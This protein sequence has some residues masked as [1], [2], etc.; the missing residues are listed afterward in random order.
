ML[1]KQTTKITAVAALITGGVMFSPIASA[2][3]L[4]SVEAE[5]QY[6]QADV[7]GG[8]AFP[9]VTWR[10]Y[11]WDSSGQTRVS[12]TITHFLPIIPNFKFDSQ[13]LEF[14]GVLLTDATQFTAIDLSHETYT[15]FYAPLDNNLTAFHFGVSLKQI[16]GFAAD[17]AGMATG[18]MMYGIKEDIYSGYLRGSFGLPFTGFSVV[19]QGH[20]GIGDHD[21]H[22][23]EAALRYRFMD[24]MLLDGF[25]SLGY[26]S[27]KMHFNDEDSAFSSN[28]EFTGPFA[29]LSLRF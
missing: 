17:N 10:D 28:Y 13:K 14:D 22:D 11:D 5:A 21:T 4:F 1:G 9:A 19:A 20:F 29:S 2:D 18:A 7:S 8:H 3:L 26:R 15:L 27:V 25:I 16:D 24:T 12:A 6:W 23:I